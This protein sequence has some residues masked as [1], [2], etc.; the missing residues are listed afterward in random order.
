[1]HPEDIH[2]IIDQAKLAWIE[3]DADTFANLFTPDGE[4]IVPGNCW[5]G[6]TEIGQT[7]A[8]FAQNNTDI[9]I[10]ISQVIIKAPTP[11]EGD[12]VLLEWHWENTQLATGKRER[13][14]DAIAIDFRGDKISRWREYID[15]KT[16]SA[17]GSNAT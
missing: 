17:S 13:A 3:G 1:M 16:V 7:I 2:T 10:Q 14:D 9:S 5:V 11:P 6:P 15:S 8:N 12:R 4:F